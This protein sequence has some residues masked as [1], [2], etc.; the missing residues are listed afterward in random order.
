M[1][2]L[3]LHAV[4]VDVGVALLT[5]LLRLLLHAALEFHVVDFLAVNFSHSVRVGEKLAGVVDRGEDEQQ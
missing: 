1:E 4:V 2:H 5:H 3:G